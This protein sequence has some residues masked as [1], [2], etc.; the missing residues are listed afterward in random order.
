MIR[1]T[2]RYVVR[3]AR[4]EELLVPSLADLHALYTHG[5]ILDGDLVRQERSNRWVPVARFPALHGVRET[6]AE[7]PAKVA[8]LFA[9][10]MALALGLGLLFAR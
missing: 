10:L 4:D 6:R 3:N 9:A 8:M 1:I 7:S 2:T 5:F